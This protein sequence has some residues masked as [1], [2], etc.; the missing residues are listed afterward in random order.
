MRLKWTFPV[1]RNVLLD[2]RIGNCSLDLTFD[3]K[4]EEWC[5][6]Q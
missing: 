6:E 1:F 4:K 2:I 5:N 3:S